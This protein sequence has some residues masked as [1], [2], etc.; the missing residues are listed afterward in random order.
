MAST[1]SKT[2]A[3]NAA[4]LQEIK[5]DHHELRERLAE[6]RAVAQETHPSIDR[7][8]PALVALRD[9]VSLHFAL[10]EAYGYC[11]AELAE[12]AP[13]LTERAM[14]LKSEHIGLFLQLGDQVDFAESLQYHE[15]PRYKIRVLCQ[16]A[17]DFCD[18]LMTHERQETELILQ[19]LDDDLGVG[20]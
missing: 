4:F 12:S 6:V 11:E 7:L 10:E 9:R 2:L 8:T 16:D 18:Q 14:E 1:L 15:C 20:D 3:I 17:L 19:A 5:E 13:W